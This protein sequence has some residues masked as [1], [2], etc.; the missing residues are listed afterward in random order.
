MVLNILIFWLK[1]NV[2]ALAL[3]AFRKDKDVIKSDVIP[4]LKKSFPYSLFSLII[5]YIALPITIVYSIIH[6]VK[7]KR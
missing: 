7:W 3:I 5:I 1:L 2:I 6:L 4:L